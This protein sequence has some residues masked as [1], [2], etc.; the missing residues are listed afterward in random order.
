M[1]TLKKSA[2]SPQPLI[3]LAFVDFSIRNR[4][5]HCC[6]FKSAENLDFTGTVAEL[7][8]FSTTYGEQETG[9]QSPSQ[10]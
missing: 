3:L 5:A 9:L 2:T 7:R 6:G 8:I 10:N 1:N 4:P